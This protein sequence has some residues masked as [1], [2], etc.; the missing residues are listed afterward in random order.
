M[1]LVFFVRVFTGLHY[2]AAWCC[3]LLQRGGGTCYLQ[4]GGGGLP[5]LPEAQKAGQVFIFILSGFAF[6]QFPATKDVWLPFY[7]SFSSV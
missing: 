2:P 4:E 3:F 7:L 5:A 1:T 6:W